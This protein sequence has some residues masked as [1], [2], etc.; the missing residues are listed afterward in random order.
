MK[1]SILNPKIYGCNKLKF[2]VLNS[3]KIN[4]YIFKANKLNP[5]SPNQI[6]NQYCF[7]KISRGLI[8]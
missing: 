4:F 7:T 8:C 2:M 5:K 6:Q 1:N 3:K